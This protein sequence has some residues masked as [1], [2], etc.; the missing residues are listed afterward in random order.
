MRAIVHLLLTSLLVAIFLASQSTVA[1]RLCMAAEAA[2]QLAET[3]KR[4]DLFDGK[5]LTGWE[6]FLLD[7]KVST[8]DVWTV[9]DGMLVCAGNPL[10]Y[11]H[12]KKKFTNFKLTLQW[13]WAPGKEPGNSGVLLRITGKPI[14]FLPKCM[15]AQ[16]MSG[17]AGDL[18]GFYGYKL[19]GAPDRLKV[20][21][22][23]KQ[24][25]NFMGV[26][27][28]KDAEKKAGEWNAYVITLD[29]GNLTVVINGEKVNEA[30]HCDIVAGS[31]GLQSEGAEIHFRNISLTE[32]P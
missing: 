28:M 19:E 31:I 4:I 25:G 22:D 24:L 13:R 11:L 23:H 1:V 27:R 15:E 16:L 2:E 9:R 30:T 18:W 12:T 7:S 14:S 6:G 21:K 32:M 8:E 29:R 10:G 26:G 3:S 17:S 5:S 20:V